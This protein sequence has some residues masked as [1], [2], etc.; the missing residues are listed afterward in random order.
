M[1]T[2]W[3]SWPRCASSRMVD[4]KLRSAPGWRME[5]RIFISELVDRRGFLAIEKPD[6]AHRH[7]EDRKNL[8]GEHRAGELERR[9]DGS[10]AEQL[11][12]RFHRV[13]VHQPSHE[14][15]LDLRQRVENGRRVDQKARGVPKPEP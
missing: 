11:D 10:V 1:N 8:Q 12:G 7:R 4:A 3:T 13:G 9:A 6:A 2:R 15:V 5:N 14:R